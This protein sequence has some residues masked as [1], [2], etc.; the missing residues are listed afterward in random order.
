MNEWLGGLCNRARERSPEQDKAKQMWM[1]SGG[2][3]KLK[4]IAAALSVLESRIRKFPIPADQ[5]RLAGIFVEESN[6]RTSVLKK[7]TEI[8]ALTGSGRFN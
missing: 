5:L 3:M 2:E 8:Y 7:R 4:D 1:E 6:L